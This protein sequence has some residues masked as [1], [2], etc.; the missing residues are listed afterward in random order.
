MV[1]GDGIDHG[2]SGNPVSDRPVRP[3][4][5]SAHSGSNLLHPVELTRY[6]SVTAAHTWSVRQALNGRRGN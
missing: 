3:L 1:V 2:A 5:R 4:S 6:V